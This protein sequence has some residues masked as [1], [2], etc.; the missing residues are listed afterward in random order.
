[1]PRQ[2]F[3]AKAPPK[4][5]PPNEAEL[6]LREA[7]GLMLSTDQCSRL[8]YADRLFR[9]GTQRDRDDAEAIIKRV[10]REIQAG[11]DETTRLAR[12]RGEEFEAPS[13]GPITLT[14]HDSLRALLKSGMLTVELF[15]YAIELRIAFEARFAGLG[16]QLSAG[17]GRAEHN[18]D[19]YVFSGLQRA[20]AMQ[21]CG[22]AERRIAVECRDDPNCQAV[23]R[24]VIAQGK[25]LTSLGRGR[26]Y[27]RNAAALARAIEAAKG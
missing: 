22:S 19:R 8:R 13:S 21:K 15:D 16:S 9:V 24:E 27:Y 4:E 2:R 18:N 25:T 1:M 20:K 23:F 26:A 10:R 5:P 7:S 12:D 11:I 6:M 14:S 3:A 17:E